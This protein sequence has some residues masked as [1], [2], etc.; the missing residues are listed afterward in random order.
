MFNKNKPP[1]YVNAWYE[2]MM[3]SLAHK[4]VSNAVEGVVY[5]NIPFGNSFLDIHIDGECGFIVFKTIVEG[6]LNIRE[7]QASSGNTVNVLLN[8]ISFDNWQNNRNEEVLTEENI[9]RISEGIVSLV[10]NSRNPVLPDCWVFPFFNYFVNMTVEERNKGKNKGKD[11]DR[12]DGFYAIHDYGNTWGCG[13]T[14]SGRVEP[15]ASINRG[16]LRLST[17]EESLYTAIAG[18]LRYKTPFARVSAEYS[19]PVNKATLAKHH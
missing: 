6:E 19:M 7:L 17:L 10:R 4:I 2:T 12:I 14:I 18:E 11:F 9:K 1:K 16:F 13:G 15:E 5:S 8:N 3:Y